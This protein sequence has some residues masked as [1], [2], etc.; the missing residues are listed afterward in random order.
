MT[1]YPGAENIEIKMPSLDTLSHHFCHFEHTCISAYV[2]KG[3]WLKLANLHCPKT[4]PEKVNIFHAWV[5]LSF[6]K[7]VYSTQQM[8][9]YLICSLLCDILNVFNLHELGWKLGLDN[10]RDLGKERLESA[11][12]WCS[13]THIHT[14]WWWGSFTCSCSPK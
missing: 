3:V 7:S 1:G 5:F 10:N 6:T 2:L 4:T 9:K 13:N 11:W 12:E 8:E 14:G